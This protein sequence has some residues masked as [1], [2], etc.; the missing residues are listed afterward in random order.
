[1]A[2][3]LLDRYFGT[4]PQAQ[5]DY[6]DFLRRYQD[7]PTTFPTKRLRAATAR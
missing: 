4:N 6:G 3:D 5:Q 1:M 2:M 7:I